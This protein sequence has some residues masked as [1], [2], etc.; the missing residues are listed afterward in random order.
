MWSGVRRI[1][2]EQAT[3]PPGEFHE[4]PKRQEELLFKYNAPPFWTSGYLPGSVKGNRERVVPSG[5]QGRRTITGSSPLP[6]LSLATLA[7]NLLH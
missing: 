4:G 1:L 7:T 3:P 2:T 6:L 5:S